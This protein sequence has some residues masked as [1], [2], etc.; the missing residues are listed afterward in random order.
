MSDASAGILTLAEVVQASGSM[1]SS[2]HWLPEPVMIPLAP[3]RRLASAEDAPVLARLLDQ[4]GGGLFPY[5]WTQLAEPGTDPWE[6]GAR[7]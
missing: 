3:L 1:R 7:L 2:P 6:Y 5:A 4:A